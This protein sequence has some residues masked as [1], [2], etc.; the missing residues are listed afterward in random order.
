MSIREQ[1]EDAKF[2]AENGKYVGALTHLMLAIA[3]SAKR[4]FPE[5]TKSLQEPK[6]KMP[7]QESF[8]L[9]LGGRLRQV[10]FGFI[11]S[12]EL[13]SAGV[14][15]MFRE[16][17]YDLAVLIYKFYRNSLIHQGKLDEDV[18]FLPPAEGETPHFI[19]GINLNIKSGNKLSLEAKWIYVFM[20]VV[21]CAPCNAAEFGLEHRKFVILEG[22]DEKVF[23]DFIIEKYATAPTKYSM[24]KH[25]VEMLWPDVK[26]LSNADISNRFI[27][28]IQSGDVSR[29]FVNSISRDGFSDANGNLSDKGVN[30]IREIAQNLKLI[31]IS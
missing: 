21:V 1:V 15:L 30:C 9:F 8:C 25:V 2:L 22:G 27:G 26:D 31:I 7:D 28:L 10:L 17:K 20:E 4:I 12:P 29:G 14:S 13:A 16:E 19:S 11:G 24:F 3:A 6:K 23:S 5:G 18:E